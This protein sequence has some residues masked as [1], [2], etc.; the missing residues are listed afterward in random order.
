MQAITISSLRNNIKHYLDRVSRSMETIIVPRSNNED[1][2]V[3]IMSI[4]EYNSLMETSYLNSTAANRRRLDESV[5]QLQEGKTNGLS[6]DELE[7][8]LKLRHGD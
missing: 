8:K 1:D 6:L 2:A 3:V 7:A 5:A 4:R